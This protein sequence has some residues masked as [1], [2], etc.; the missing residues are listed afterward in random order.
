MWVS[1]I[2]A[3]LPLTKNIQVGS[4][5]SV[6]PSLRRIY[7]SESP[8]RNGR[9]V[10][11]SILTC[12]PLVT[13]APLGRAL[14]PAHLAITRDDLWQR[15]GRHDFNLIYSTSGLQFLRDQSRRNSLNG[16]LRPRDIDLVIGIPLP[17][18]SYQDN[19]GRCRMSIHHRRRPHIARGSHLAHR[20]LLLTGRRLTRVSHR[21]ASH[22]AS[23]PSHP[24]HLTCRH[25]PNTSH[26][27]RLTCRRLTLLSFDLR[28]LPT[29]WVT[30]FPQREL[31][32]QVPPYRDGYSLSHAT[33][34]RD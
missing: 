23:H 5:S 34:R 18:H 3:P 27:R 8:Q 11:L 13:S 32:L 19:Q 15:L 2:T 7:C 24:G 30:E 12:A 9:D 1:I 25:L 20:A 14:S 6:S 17:S 29:S 26:L 16:P 22:R 10:A 28:G 4:P 33:E 31:A 21:R